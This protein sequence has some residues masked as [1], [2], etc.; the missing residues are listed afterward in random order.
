MKTDDQGLT[1]SKMASIAISQVFD[2]EVRLSLAQYL[3]QQSEEQ[4]DTI[5]NGDL[6]SIEEILTS[7]LNVLNAIFIDHSIVIVKFNREEP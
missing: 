4:L 7:Q 1:P 2:S 5:N 6:S 3:Q